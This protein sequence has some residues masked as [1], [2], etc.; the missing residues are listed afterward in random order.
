[1]KTKLLT[2][3]LLLFTAQVFAGI[4]DD[5][6][7]KLKKTNAC[8]GCDLRNA[9]LFN[10]SL[11]GANLNGA[12]LNGA[13]FTQADLSYANLSGADLSKA[14]FTRANLS[15]ANLA[16]ANFTKTDFPKANLNQANLFYADLSGADL[17]GAD[18]SG[19]DLSG[20]DLSGAD[21]S[22]AN[23]SKA[24]LSDA[25][26]SGANLSKANLSN[27]IL[28][29]ADFSGANL[30]KVNLTGVDL[31]NVNSSSLDY[32]REVPPDYGDNICE[33]SP[34]NLKKYELVLCDQFVG[35]IFQ[36]HDRKIGLPKDH[37][38]EYFTL[39][40]NGI[41]GFTYEKRLNRLFI[42]ATDYRYFPT[43]I[44]GEKIME[45]ARRGA[46]VIPLQNPYYPDRVHFVHHL[47]VFPTESELSKIT[48]RK[49]I[50]SYRELFPN[51]CNISSSEY[52]EYICEWE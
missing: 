7:V 41:E 44:D 9:R 35:T 17:S 39:S 37:N 1:M 13:D 22:N 30:S 42:I 28:S 12:N 2:I 40:S 3:F 4:V 11:A 8:V 23:L 10:L 26:L 46:V 33:K 48:S 31:K 16:D 52:Y 36:T 18:L 43:E 15:E 5:N 14:D 21:L 38:Y 29:D 20:A 49:D 6:I 27:S 51:V 34:S 19:A 47:A 50:K 24:N 25:D 45:K 32:M